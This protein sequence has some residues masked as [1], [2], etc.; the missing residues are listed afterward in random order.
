MLC[1]TEYIFRF[2]KV[3]NHLEGKLLTKGDSVYKKAV[4]LFVHSLYPASILHWMKVLGVD[5]IKIINSES[6]RVSSDANN[7]EVSHLFY[8]YFFKY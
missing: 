8:F 7:Q 3:L 5:R 2:D 1:F 4:N 6:L